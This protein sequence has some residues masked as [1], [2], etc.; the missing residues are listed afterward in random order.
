ME[1][2]QQQQPPSVCSGGGGGTPLFHASIYTSIV[3]FP[4]NPHRTPKK[5]KTH[6]HAGGRP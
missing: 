3:L 1:G 6:K 2:Q 4:I 5:P